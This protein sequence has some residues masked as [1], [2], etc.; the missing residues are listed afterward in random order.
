[1]ADT[2]QDT[3]T[4]TEAAP[5]S[6]SVE[7]AGPARKRLVIEVPQEQIAAKLADSLSQLSNEAV[8]PGFRPGKAPRRLLERK[9]GT[10][11]RDDVRAQLVSESYAK[12]I[13][14]EKL[15]VIGEPE[16]KDLDKI[17]LP[18][19]GS[20]KFE[21]EC[22]VVPNVELP[23]FASIQVEKASFEVTDEDVAKEI[24]QQQERNGTMAAA[25][26]SAIKAGDFAQ[27]EVRILKG[28]DAGD[29]AE[30]IAK[31]A[32]VY[33]MVN[34]E[35]AQYRGH[36][37]GIVVED[38]GKQL[39]D[40]KV[41]DVVRISMTG[42]KQHEND[43]I[44]EQPITL[45]IKIDNIERLQPADI[46]TLLQ[47]TGMESEDAL[48]ARV[49]EMLQARKER[50]QQAA[51]YDQVRDQ[52]LAKV[53]LTLPE[54]LTGRQAARVLQRQAMELAY[55][56]MPE[57]EIEAAIA[58][59]RSGSEE[60]AQRDLKLFFILDK[61]ARDLDVQVDDRELNG[62]IAMIAMQQGRRPEKVRQQMQRS[63]EI[64]SLYLS[65]REQATL[66]KILEKAQVTAVDKPAEE[67]AK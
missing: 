44:R 59:A 9:F 14:Q 49:R 16:I 26:D 6:V 5:V 20:L 7:D 40:K 29:D 58:E 35:S 62:R 56:G 30:E 38:L 60:A 21:V 27:A 15:E 19:T 10:A 36:V 61:A 39:A 18:E 41:G 54:K 1:M 13:E 53:E 48:K 32:G 23:D 45:V 24:E 17:E 37:V 3:P 51:I 63:G 50:Q 43:A 34:G 42:P 47:R 12:A 22:E 66:D 8:V 25:G 31:H 52:L 4:E 55:R 2:Q 33:I 46:A 65:L 28:S 67:A 64:E 57:K 11:M